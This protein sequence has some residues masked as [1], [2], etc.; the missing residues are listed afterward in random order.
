[1]NR[2]VS[3]RSLVFGGVA[4]TV[5]LCV[6]SVVLAQD[7]P[8]PAAGPPTAPPPDATNAQ[9]APPP[10]NYPPPPP[11]SAT[12]APAYQYP[13]QYP[14]GSRYPGYPPP[15]PA[16]APYYPPPR[17]RRSSYEYYPQTDGIYRPFSLTLAIGPGFLRG[18]YS[19]VDQGKAAL[20]Y[21]LV[22]LGFGIAPNLQFILA[23]EGTG[24]NTIAGDTGESAWLSQQNWLLGLQYYMLR[25]LYVRGAA[26]VASI[27]EHT[28]SYDNPGLTGI[29]MSAGIGVE[30]VQSQ[31]AAVGLD[32]NGSF[33]SYSGEHWETG[34]LDLAVTFF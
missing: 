22:R 1:M 16:Y 21:N 25:R 23:F 29:A 34:G 33:N 26:G 18:P 11:R 14:Q 4:L 8:P 24:A 20:S 17:V 2:A 3:P 6:P 5:A 7:A 28:A 9:P 27:S 31:H 10:G 30:L 32:L 19:D 13:Q 15:P 12:P